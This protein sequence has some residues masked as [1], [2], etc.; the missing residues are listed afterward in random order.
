MDTDRA[1]GA[2]VDTVTADRHLHYF[3]RGCTHPLGHS[4]CTPLVD[5]HCPVNVDGH[6]C[7]LGLGNVRHHVAASPTA[8]DSIHL[9]FSEP[10]PDLAPIQ[11]ERTEPSGPGDAVA[12][13]DTA[14]LRDTGG[15][16]QDAD[17]GTEPAK[18]N[19]SLGD[20]AGTALGYA[21]WWAVAFTLVA[22][23][24]CVRNPGR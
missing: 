20:R 5:P 21:V 15:A 6:R 4:E 16:D 2:H 18:P 14:G 3:P 13:S 17:P 22:I 24:L 8:G 7:A 1:T 19:S 23:A 12:G 10:H 11:W 9:R